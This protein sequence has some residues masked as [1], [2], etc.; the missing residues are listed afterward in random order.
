[1]AFARNDLPTP[2]V[3]N[4]GWKEQRVKLEIIR[5]ETDQPV[6]QTEFPLARNEIKHATPSKPLSA[7]TYYLKVTP[8]KSAP[9]VQ[10]FS[11]Y[12]Y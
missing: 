7:G 12:G 2:V 9:I 6:F 11:V 1:M 4:T 5:Q 8:E 3:Q 10:N